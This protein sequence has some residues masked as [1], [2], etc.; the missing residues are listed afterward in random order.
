MRQIYEKSKN[1]IEINFQNNVEVILAFLF[2]QIIFS[3]LNEGFFPFISMYGKVCLYLLYLLV[4]F[5]SILKIKKVKLDL[6]NLL[7]IFLSVFCLISISYN[8]EFIY[9]FKEFLKIIFLLFLLNVCKN[10]DVNKFYRNF[11]LFFKIFLPIFILVLIFGYWKFDFFNQNFPGTSS[12]LRNLY[13]DEGMSYYFLNLYFQNYNNLIAPFNAFIHFY[14]ISLFLILNSN[15]VLIKNFIFFIFNLLFLLI[16]YIYFNLTLILILILILI[17]SFLIFNY[18]KFL[19]IILLKLLF[20]LS[21]FIPIMIFSVD[22]NSYISKF[23]SKFLYNFAKVTNSQYSD[24]YYLKNNYFIF[25]YDFDAYN[26]RY[27]PRIPVLDKYPYFFEN[28]KFINY[29]LPTLVNTDLILIDFLIEDI[30]YEELKLFNEKNDLKTLCKNFLNSK[31]FFELKMEANQYLDNTAKKINTFNSHEKEYLNRI[32]SRQYP[33]IEIDWNWVTL[34][35][36]LPPFYQIYYSLKSRSHIIKQH[37]DIISNNLIFG[38]G[39][40][41]PSRDW[42]I[43][44]IYKELDQNKPHNTF[45]SFAEMYGFFTFILFCLIL[46]LLVCNFN[47]KGFNDYIALIFFLLMCNVE[48]YLVGASLNTFVIGWLLVFLIYH[49]KNV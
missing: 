43:N 4:L 46:Y 33:F 41:I 29:C 5:F 17:F 8:E 15:S 6:L 34:R 35:K 49:K 14:V 48:D 21:V 45:V 18:L 32:L 10:I 44:N 25:A 47:R 9:S 24:K 36:D 23:Y 2:S 27:Y 42:N 20:G 39:G 3:Y 13:E 7:I 1:L 38:L 12:S 37:T 16:L 31:S 19:K 22:V 26:E 40:Y 28:Q 30:K 11:Y